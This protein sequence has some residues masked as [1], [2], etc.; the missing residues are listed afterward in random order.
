M[1]RYNLYFS[2]PLEPRQAGNIIPDLA[3]NFD[4]VPF[5]ILA[6]IRPEGVV[7]SFS[8][9]WLYCITIR[10]DLWV[11]PGMDGDQVD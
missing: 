2:L 9:W 3:D 7:Y 4:E 11:C 10:V 5:I 8:C 6:R 1:T